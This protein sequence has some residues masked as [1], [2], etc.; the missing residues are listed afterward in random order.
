L[1]LC[2]QLLTAMLH[3]DQLAGENQIGRSGCHLQILG[4][5]S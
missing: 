3:I 1:A 5:G 2:I 4:G